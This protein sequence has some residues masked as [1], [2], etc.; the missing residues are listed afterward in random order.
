MKKAPRVLFDDIESDVSSKVEFL[1]KQR[2]LLKEIIRDYGYIGTKINVLESTKILVHKTEII[3]SE[4]FLSRNSNQEQVHDELRSP[5]LGGDIQ[6]VKISYMGGTI[7]KHE[8][9]MLKRL[10]FRAMR[11]QAFTHFYEIPQSE[12]DNLHNFNDKLVFVIIYHQG[13]FV[14]NRLRK[15]CEACTSDPVLDVRK[16]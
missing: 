11:G 9:M 16:D 12:S 1:R 8:Q 3:D 2:A 13:D 14:Y 6:R 10:V 5:L 7:L 15:I 4:Q